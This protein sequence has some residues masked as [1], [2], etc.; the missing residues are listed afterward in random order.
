MLGLLSQNDSLSE[1]GDTV[2][3]TLGVASG[4][5]YYFKVLAAGSGTVGTVG[6]YGL[7][8]NFGPDAQSPIPPPNTVVPQQP[9]AGGGVAENAIEAVEGIT[10]LD[11][12]GL[13]GTPTGA[14]WTSIGDLSG[15]VAMM[16]A[17][18]TAAGAALDFEGTFVAAAARSSPAPNVAGDSMGAL[19]GPS[20]TDA[21]PS[22]PGIGPAGDA[23][24]GQDP[25]PAASTISPAVDVAYQAVDAVIQGWTARHERRATDI[26]KKHHN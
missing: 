5:K 3:V 25:G 11:G 7:L 10:G 22:T 21:T 23:D 19:L 18:A 16:Y 26:L 4:Q 17:P 13:T 14:T 1:A 6:S 20:M 2:S 15:Y 9:N 24:T 8:L 12:I